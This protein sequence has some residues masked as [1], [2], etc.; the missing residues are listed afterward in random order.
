MKA[1]SGR[2]EVEATGSLERYDLN[3]LALHHLEGGRVAF[4]RRSGKLEVS[5]LDGK[6]S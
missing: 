6:T 3:K 1:T 2:G 5:V 4:K